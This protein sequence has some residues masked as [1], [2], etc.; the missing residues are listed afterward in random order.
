MGARAVKMA[1]LPDFAYEGPSDLTAA[2]RGTAMHTCLQLIDYGQIRGIDIAAAENYTDELMLRA[3][4]AGFL[5]Q[6]SAAAVHKGLLAGYLCSALA[7]RIAAADE[8]IKELPFTQL[9]ELGGSFTA[10][11]GIIDCLIREEDKYT[12]IDFKTDDRVDAEKYRIQLDCYTE[13]VRKAFGTEP[14]RIVYF[15]KQNKEVRI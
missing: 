4:D 2:E 7:Q 1:E 3:L 15:L 10:V 8:V 11:Q 9:M 5:N 14:E 12:I 6:N 13:S